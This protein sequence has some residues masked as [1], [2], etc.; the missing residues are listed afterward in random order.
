MLKLTR[1]ELRLIAVACA[2]A[3]PARFQEGRDATRELKRLALVIA[4]Y[5]GNDQERTTGVALD[6]Q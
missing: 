1:K 5:T 4:E 3:N 6:E 2:S